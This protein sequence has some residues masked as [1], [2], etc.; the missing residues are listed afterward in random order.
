M[1]PLCMVNEGLPNCRLVTETTPA[2]V[3]TRVFVEVLKE[4]R[5][6]DEVT[7][8]ACLLPRLLAW[9]V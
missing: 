1:P 8:L 9:I 3:L 5:P 4:I 2:M 6:G 7:F